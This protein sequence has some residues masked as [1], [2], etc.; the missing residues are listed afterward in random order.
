MKYWI[1][2]MPDPI[3]FGDTSLRAI[4]LA[5]SLADPVNVP[6]GGCVESVV[7]LRTQFFAARFFVTANKRSLF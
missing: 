5:M 3:P 1:I 7:T 2:R 6:G 4:F